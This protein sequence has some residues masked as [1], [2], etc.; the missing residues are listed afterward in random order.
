MISSTWSHDLF[1]KYMVCESV[2][3]VR[4]L[5]TVILTNLLCLNFDCVAYMKVGI[6]SKKSYTRKSFQD[7]SCD[8]IHNIIYK[9]LLSRVILNVAD[10]TLEN[11]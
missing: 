11:L 3:L 6:S 10:F 2:F 9:A 1:L 8:L 7:K 4:K 5:H